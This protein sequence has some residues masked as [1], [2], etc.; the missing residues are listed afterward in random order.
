MPIR[1]LDAITKS[2]YRILIIDK[3]RNWFCNP[4]PFFAVMRLEPNATDYQSDV[5]SVNPENSFGRRLTYRMLMKNAR[6][7]HQ[8]FFTED[9]IRWMDQT[10]CF[11]E[12]TSVVWRIWFLLAWVF[13]VSNIHV[14]VKSDCRSLLLTFKPAGLSWGAP[15]KIKCQV[16][17]VEA[18]C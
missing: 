15:G 5:F 3:H 13:L 14:H 1:C 2:L 4:A 18:I 10:T 9:T 11:F 17:S 6:I 12:T 7:N 16:Q 8:R